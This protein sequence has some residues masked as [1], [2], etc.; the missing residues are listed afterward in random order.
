MKISNRQVSDIG[1][2]TE[3]FS[4]RGQALIPESVSVQPELAKSSAGAQG[5]SKCR[6]PVVANLLESK[7][8]DSEGG[9]DRKHLRR[10]LN[11]ALVT[12]SL[13]AFFTTTQC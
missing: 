8:K 4:K 10:E 6:E 13:T 9:A 12:N 11:K 5:P 3:R 7:I 1:A 2:N